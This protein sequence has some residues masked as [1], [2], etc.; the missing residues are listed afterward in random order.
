MS[1]PRYTI[2]TVPYLCDC[3]GTY[4]VFQDETTDNKEGRI[5]EISAWYAVCTKCGRRLD[6][7]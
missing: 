5:V 2:M 7:D 1:E 4:Q 6:L 3:G